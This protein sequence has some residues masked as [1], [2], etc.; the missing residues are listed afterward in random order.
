V[1]LWDGDL[2]PEVA[3]LR[4][5]GALVALSA[6]E[7]A[8]A[9]TLLG[10]EVLSLSWAFLAAGAC[11]VLASLWPVYD[12]AT[13]GMMRVF[14]AARRQHGDAALALAQAQ[15]A[16]IAAH[17]APGDLSTEPQCWGSFVLI[18]ESQML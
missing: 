17:Q 14:Y 9:D 13:I 1:K 11:G 12:V 6:C 10:E 8:A 2:L 18:G 16:L 4:L 15:R 7:G 5:D 3:G